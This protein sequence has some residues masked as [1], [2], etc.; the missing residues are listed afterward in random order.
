MLK[1]LILILYFLNIQKSFLKKYP[2]ILD[3]IMN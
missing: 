1:N 3:F 2:E